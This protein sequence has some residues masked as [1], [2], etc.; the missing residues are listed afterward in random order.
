MSCDLEPIVSLNVGGKKFTT[1][2]ETLCKVNEGSHLYRNSDAFEAASFLRS[3][4]LTF[5]KGLALTVITSRCERA[6]EFTWQVDHE[7]AASIIGKALWYACRMAPPC[8]PECSAVVCQAG[9][10][11]R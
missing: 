11:K 2:R 8:W 10:T 6:S 7:R 4:S 9:V 3:A 1:S 5:V